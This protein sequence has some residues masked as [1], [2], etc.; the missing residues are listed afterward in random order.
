MN[1]DEGHT[2][3]GILLGHEKHK[4]MP[5]VATWVQ[6]AIIILSEVSQNEEDKYRLMLLICGI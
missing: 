5:L 6:L 2:Y 1:K 3:N 4:I